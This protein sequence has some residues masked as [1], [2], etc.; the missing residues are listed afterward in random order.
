MYKNDIDVLNGS[1][2]H[3][4]CSIGNKQFLPDHY[5][6]ARNDRDKDGKGGVIIIHKDNLLVQELPQQKAE[7]VSI[8]IEK[9]IILTACHRPPISEA[10]YNIQ[11]VK[12]ITNVVRNI[13]ET[14]TGFVER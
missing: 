9:T 1:E 13:S 3:L 8:K 11:L 4:S 2:S 14:H 5:L 7:I 6:A 10:S 12:D